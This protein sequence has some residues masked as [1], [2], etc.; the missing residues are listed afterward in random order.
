MSV[1]DWRRKLLKD[2]RSWRLVA[3]LMLGSTCGA[4]SVGCADGGSVTGG[5]VGPGAARGVGPA[6]MAGRGALGGG[7]ADRPMEG[8][9]GCP[10]AAATGGGGGASGGAAAAG[11]AWAGHV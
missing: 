5:K 3:S 2:C 8:V 1:R 7:G 10:G 9:S 4:L 11:G 6:T